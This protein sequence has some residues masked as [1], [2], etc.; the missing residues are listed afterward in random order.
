MPTDDALARF[1]RRVE[2]DARWYALARDRC[3]DERLWRQ[4]NALLHQ[5]DL[6]RQPPSALVARTG[7]EFQPLSIPERR[8]K[9]TGH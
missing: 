9:P 7:L 4:L 3:G 8:N 2:F 6:I 1:R 5:F